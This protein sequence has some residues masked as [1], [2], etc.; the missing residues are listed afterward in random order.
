M[1]RPGKTELQ[2][3]SWR[4]TV[5]ENASQ[6]QNSGFSLFEGF[7]GDN[8]A[9]GY[10]YSQKTSMYKLGVYSDKC[11]SWKALLGIYTI[12]KHALTSFVL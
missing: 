2:Q 6:K 3:Q 1:L 4:S 8:T 9:D 7:Q 10:F 11:F 5:L 12:A